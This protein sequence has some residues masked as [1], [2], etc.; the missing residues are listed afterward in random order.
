MTKTHFNPNDKHRFIPS[1][2]LVVGA[3]EGRALSDDSAH[4]DALGD[5]HRRLMSNAVKKGI[6]K[7]RLMCVRDDDEDARRRR[8]CA[9]TR[10]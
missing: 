8:G 10:E 4:S 7:V 5:G 6:D 1:A 9:T 3:L 2:R